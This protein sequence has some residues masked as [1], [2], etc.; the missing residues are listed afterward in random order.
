M[1]VLTGAAGFIGSV[2]LKKLN[3]MGHNDVI[4][5][6]NLAESVKWKNL[7]GKNF[8][9][10]YNKEHFLEIIEG[11]D[12]SNSIEAIFHLGACSS[13]TELNMDYLII[14]NLNYSKFLCEYALE[15]EIPFHYA[16]SAATYGLGENGFSDKFFDNLKPLNPYGY[17]KYLFDKWLLDNEL[18]DKVTGYKY[19]NVFGPNEYHKGNM[20]SMIFKSYHQILEKGQVNLFKSNNSK[21][22]DGGQIRDFIYVKDI[23]EVMY[24]FYK[25]DIKGIYNLGTGVKKSWNDLASAV[26][27]AL[28]KD[29]K[30]N[31]IDMPENIKGQYQNFTLA[32]MKKFNR[33]LDYKFMT[34]EDSVTDYVQNYLVKEWQ[35]I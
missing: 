9:T 34:F 28:G 8:T 19:F 15:Y 32:D 24:K 7:I 31:Y 21:Y 25:K 10:Y 27:N 2:F 14:N 11:G 4:I 29:V 20:A 33:V 22:S 18:L 26:F 3:N 35:F 12:L 23:V 30:I 17:S 16:S 13:T 6:D 5:V 1:I